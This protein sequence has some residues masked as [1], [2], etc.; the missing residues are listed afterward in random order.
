M[1]PTVFILD[2]EQSICEAL[3]FSL[4]TDYAVEYSTNPDQA[5]RLLR[6]KSFDVL[7]LDMRLGTHNGMDILQSVRGVNLDTAVILMTAYGSENAAVEAMKKGAFDFLNKPLDIEKLKLTIG[8]ARW[9][10]A[11]NPCSTCSA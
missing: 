5:L 2:D 7:L 6:N 8:R 11:A 10:A 3:Y 4:Q 1:K 9:W